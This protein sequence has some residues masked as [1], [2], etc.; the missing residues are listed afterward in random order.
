MKVEK[1][2]QNPS[3]FLVAIE[4]YHKNLKIWKKK[5]EI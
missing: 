3:I 4:T 5:F 2:I 1:K